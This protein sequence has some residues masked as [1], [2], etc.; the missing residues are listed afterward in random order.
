MRT[1]IKI[2]AVLFCLL[3]AVPTWA[4]DDYVAVVGSGGAAACT[5]GATLLSENYETGY[6]DDEEWDEHNWSEEQATTNVYV[7]DTDVKYAGSVSGKIIGQSG[8]ASRV[9]HRAFTQQSSGKITVE[10]WYRVAVNNQPVPVFG[11]DLH[12]QG[13]WTSSK[14]F[15][16]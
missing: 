3:L 1:S 13:G 7:A 6:L 8:D 14:K 15:Y 4:E 10:L 5:R 12:N 2:L 16:Y 9:I 11:D